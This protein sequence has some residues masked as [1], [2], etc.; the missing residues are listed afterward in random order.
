MP[1][2]EVEHLVKNYNKV[3]AVKDVSFTVAEGQ[4]FGFLGPNGAGKTTTINILCTLLK[5]TSGRAAVNGWDV[6]EHP[7]KVRES[8]GMV[9]QDISLDTRLTAWE[10]LDFHGRIYGVPKA[11][12]IKRVAEALELVD[13]EPRQRDLVKTF[14][15]GM[16]RRLELARGLLHR[17]KI[18]FLDEPT[19]GLD[20]QTR[21]KMWKFILGL[22]QQKEVTIFLTTH[23]MDEAENCDHIAIIDRGEI[24]AL[25]T[26]DNL[27]HSV[28]GDIITLKT[29]DNQRAAA[30]I[31]AQFGLV[32]TA[33][34]GGLHFEVEKGEEFIPRF[35]P[36]IGTPITSIS[37]RR[38]TLDDV[39]LQMTGRAIRESG[40][41]DGGRQYA[42]HRQTKT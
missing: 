22:K 15:G 39:F 36:A 10:N 23:Y 14:S 41:E 8:I 11:T 24:I 34:D 28:G 26:P 35:L 2:I 20:P 5:P 1:I 9:F 25:D 17:P 13:L 37:L 12:R 33:D 4:V 7:L 29:K 38:P 42:R 32:C 19:L 18:L 30:E 40:P 6:L 31:Q 21:A 16:K 27:K 3:V